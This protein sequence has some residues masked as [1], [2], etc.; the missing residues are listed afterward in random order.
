MSLFFVSAT[1]YRREL[2]SI[3]LYR[4]GFLRGG[5]RGIKVLRWE[6]SSCFK[7]ASNSESFLI[8]GIE[9]LRLICNKGLELR[10]AKHSLCMHNFVS[11]LSCPIFLHRRDRT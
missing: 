6:L 7:R 9:M 5:F 2:Y 10:V 4:K 1:V 11:I 8:S 3:F